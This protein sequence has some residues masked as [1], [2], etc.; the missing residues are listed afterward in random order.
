M[1]PPGQRLRPADRGEAGA[2]D[3]P[4]GLLLVVE[5]DPD[6]NDLLATLLTDA[7]Y[8]VASAADGD[9][10]LRLAAAR[11][12]DAVVLDLLLPRITGWEI[13]ERLSAAAGR[14]VP[15]V[16]VSAA[17]PSLFRLPPS[18]TCVVPKPFHADTLLMALNGALGATPATE[19]RKAA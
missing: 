19:S 10:A 2:A 1:S 12:L 7:G 4:R 13:A 11:P 3:T 18:V 8:E 5:D 9:E 14:P 6:V 15:I 17:P 16:V